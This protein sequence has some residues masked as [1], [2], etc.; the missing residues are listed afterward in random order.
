MMNSDNLV[1]YQTLFDYSFDKGKNFEFYFVENNMSSVVN[2]SNG[3]RQSILRKSLT[4]K[5]CSKGP[6]FSTN[7]QNLISLKKA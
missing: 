6:R 7:Y 1:V 2:K 5:R 3:F 4:R